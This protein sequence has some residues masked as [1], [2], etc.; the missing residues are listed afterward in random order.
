MKCSPIRVD[1]ATRPGSV[2][3]RPEDFALVVAIQPPPRCGE[4]TRVSVN[5]A[6]LAAT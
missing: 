3:M 4:S 1:A 2:K 6:S 5:A